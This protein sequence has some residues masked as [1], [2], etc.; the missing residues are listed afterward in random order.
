VGGDAVIVKVLSPPETVKLNQKGRVGPFWMSVK[1]HSVENV[2]FMY[3]VNASKK[4]DSIVSA[5]V[6]RELGIGLDAL[7]DEMRIHTTKGTSEP[8]DADIIFDGLIRL[9]KDQGLYQVNDDARV[10]IKEGKL[11]RHVVDFPSAA[12]EGDYLVQTYVFDKGGLVGTAT[13]RLHVRKVGLE[14]H[15]V[16]WAKTFPNVYGVCAVILALGAGLLV[17]FVFRKGGH[18]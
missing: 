8:R 17:G 3:L 1:Q 5:E 14:A 2:P 4:L 12:K 15:I 9:K 18:H 16:H 7:R 11:F 6:L 10:S 13:D